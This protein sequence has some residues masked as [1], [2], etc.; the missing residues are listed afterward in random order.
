MECSMSDISLTARAAVV[1]LP[2]KIILVILVLGLLAASG[3]AV[4]PV[5]FSDQE[6]LTQMHKDKAALYEGQE[7]LDHPLSLAEAIARALKYNYDHRLAMMESVL[8]DKQLDLSTLDMLPRLVATAG[9]HGR[10]NE[11]ASNSISYETRKETLEASVS[12]EPHRFTGDL[13]LTWNILDFGV[14]YYQAKQQADRYLIA[15]EQRRKVMNQIAGEA[16]LLYYRA[17]TAEKMLPRLEEILASAQDALD[18]YDTIEKEQLEPLLPV[19]EQKRALLKL[20]AHLKGLKSDLMLAKSQLAALVSL[21]L[22]TPYAM[23]GSGDETTLPEIQTSI[24]DLESLG[25]MNRPDMREHSYKERIGRHDV[26]KEL[27][28]L[29]PGIELS[30]SLMYDSNKYFVNNFWAE[31]GAVI[32]A[33]IFDLVKGPKRIGIAETQVEINKVRRLALAMAAVVQINI[34]YRKYMQAVEA[35]D[36]ATQ[37]NDVEQRILDIVSEAVLLEAESPL[38]R[39]QRQT[40]AILAEMEREWALAEAFRSL[41]DLYFSTG[42]DMFSG[43]PE[44]LELSTLTAQVQKSLDGF[45]SGEFPAVPEMVEDEI[46]LQGNE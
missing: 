22:Y 2:L 14:S 28:R 39:V 17:V 42:T 46:Q 25:L 19:L 36:S 9:Y 10:S 11:Q 8:Q 38:E 32:T 35:Y 1:R 30:G 41:G 18:A 34:S 24:E 15:L 29:L 44:T 43:L 26:T 13:T 12:Q 6:R 16:V 21:P 45:Y 33:N 31:A 5:P 27:L 37:V 3:C 20:I 4:K 23:D 40:S 7:P